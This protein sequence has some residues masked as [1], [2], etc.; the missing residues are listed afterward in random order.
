MKPLPPPS[1]PTPATESDGEE[2]AGWQRRRDT[3]D[4][5]ST[6]IFDAL[7]QWSS[8]EDNGF[9]YGIKAQDLCE[10]EDHASRAYINYRDRMPEYQDGD[11]EDGAVHA[12]NA[13][14]DRLG[15]LQKRR[16]QKRREQERPAKAAR[17]TTGKGETLV[18]AIGEP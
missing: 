4:Q 10:A 2:E 14:R 11:S 6:D 13:F 8:K 17:K 1:S 3:S 12:Y 16:L 5:R 7:V 18:I 9:Y 15:S